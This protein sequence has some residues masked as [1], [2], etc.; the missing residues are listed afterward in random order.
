M[1]YP[2]LPWIANWTVTLRE[3]EDG[4]HTVNFEAV[5][6]GLRDNFD[7]P[8]EVRDFLAGVFEGDR[9]K[10]GGQGAPTKEYKAHHRDI[11]DTL[12]GGR[13]IPREMRDYIAVLFE[14]DRVKRT[15]RGRPPKENW[16]DRQ[17]THRLIINEYH[18]QL[19]LAR[20]NKN[21]ADKGA[22]TPHEI[23]LRKAVAELAKL[24]GLNMGEDNIKAIIRDHRTEDTDFD[25][26]PFWEPPLNRRDK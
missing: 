21:R 12:R 7:V 22:G 11:V 1:V 13:P 8:R 9:V 26:D 2:A 14:T 6:E 16:F 3:L 17:N 4:E 5:S 10:R 25:E 15:R 23:A 20:L 24:P 19:H 18:I